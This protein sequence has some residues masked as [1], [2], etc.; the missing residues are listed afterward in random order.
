MRDHALKDARMTDPRPRRSALYLPGSNPRAIEKARTLAADV[1]IL[2]LEDS[3]AP[4]AKVEARGLACEA[5]ASGG[6]GPR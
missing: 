5:V 3:V 1:V 6:F 2:D 4:D